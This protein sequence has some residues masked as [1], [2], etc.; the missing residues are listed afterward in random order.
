MLLA[1][2]GCV[3]TVLAAHAAALVAP[4]AVSEAARSQMAMVWLLVESDSTSSSSWAS[5][6]GA[7]AAVTLGATVQEA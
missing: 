4:W 7:M 3:P 6:S 2:Q 5:E 1:S